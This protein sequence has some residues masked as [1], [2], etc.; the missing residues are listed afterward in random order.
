VS[1][2]HVDPGYDGKLKFA[3]YNAGS[4]NIPLTVGS[5]VFLLWLSL[6]DTK[7]EEGY[8]KKAGHKQITDD[9]VRKLQGEIASPAN[10]LKNFNEL[11]LDL[12][13]LN[14]KFK[15]SIAVFITLFSGLIIMLSSIFFGKIFE[16]SNYPAKKIE[17]ID[18]NKY[19]NKFSKPV[20]KIIK[21]KNIKNSN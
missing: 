14:N 5:P 13:K 3:V 6:L 17:N 12:D 16:T 8:T 19:N 10:L 2:F 11:K 20:K 7:T 21:K 1:G 9:D 15:I 4:T 18:N